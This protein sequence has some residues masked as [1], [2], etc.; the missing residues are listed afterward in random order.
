MKF[1]DFPSENQSFSSSNFVKN[2]KTIFKNLQSFALGA[3]QRFSN[4]ADLEKC[5]QMIIW[6]QTSASIQQRTSLSNFGGDPIHF[7]NALL[8]R[9]RFLRTNPQ[10]R[11][12]VNEY[13][14][15]PRELNSCTAVR[16]AAQPAAPSQ[17]P[18]RPL[19]PNIPPKFPASILLG[20]ISVVF[21]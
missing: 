12:Y 21:G 13:G 14:K 7:F 15:R 8:M 20:D 16:A 2:W 11:R 10:I 9:G 3:V 4:L 17:V 5:C 1:R 6:L 19:R 18:R